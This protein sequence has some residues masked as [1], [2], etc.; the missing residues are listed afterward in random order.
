MFK[1]RLEA[2]SVIGFDLALGTEI[3]DR[4]LDIE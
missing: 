2:V 1:N 3:K 4:I